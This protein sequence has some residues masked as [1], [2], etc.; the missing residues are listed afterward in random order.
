MNPIT[1]RMAVRYSEQSEFEMPLGEKKT[2]EHRLTPRTVARASLIR[3][4]LGRHKLQLAIN[5]LIRSYEAT[6]G[7]SV[8]RLDYQAGSGRV[9]CDAIPA[10]R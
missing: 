3:H 8:V 7:F 2:E 4:A 5:D 10:T 9:V 6:T 1:C